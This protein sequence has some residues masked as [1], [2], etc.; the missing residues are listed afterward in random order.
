MF[1]NDVMLRGGKGVDKGGRGLSIFHRTGPLGRFDL[2]VA[3]SV[4]GMSPSHAIFWRPGT[5]ACVPC[6]WTGACARRPRVEPYKRGGVPNWT[7][8]PQECRNVGI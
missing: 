4:A 5:G 8:H 6:P 3:K 1:I 2:V 7:H